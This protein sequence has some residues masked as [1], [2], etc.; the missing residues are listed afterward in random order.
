[1]YSTFKEGEMF[2]GKYFYLELK[3]SG[4]ADIGFVCHQFFWSSQAFI[5]E[6]ISPPFFFPKFPAPPVKQFTAEAEF[7]VSF[8]LS[9][10]GRLDFYCQHGTHM[11]QNLAEQSWS[12]SSDMEV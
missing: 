2:L 7:L 9:L 6:G 8:R 10:A 11:P 1:M 12:E 3:L 4:E 5:V